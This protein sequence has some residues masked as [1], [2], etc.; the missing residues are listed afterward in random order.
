MFFCSSYSLLL[1]FPIIM[2]YTRRN[3]RTV[4]A[5]L[6]FDL[7]W[8]WPF[9]PIFHKVT[10]WKL[11]KFYDC[12]NNKKKFSHM[13]FIHLWFPC[14]NIINILHAF[15][16]NFTPNCGCIYRKIFTMQRNMENTAMQQYAGMIAKFMRPSW[17]PTGA[18]RAQVGPMLAPWTLLSGLPLNGDK[19]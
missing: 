4:L 8:H 17:G 3:I 11:G 10:S 19:T 2:K 6:C 13:Y 18:D 12:L 5:F 14:Y 16:T 9:L 15:P 1:W 7:V